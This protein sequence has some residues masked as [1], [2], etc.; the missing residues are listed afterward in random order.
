MNGFED[1]AFQDFIKGL[2]KLTRETGYEVCE[3]M[4]ESAVVDKDGNHVAYIYFHKNVG[5]YVP[6]KR[7]IERQR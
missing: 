4:D 1:V 6:R 7:R 2:S 5:R 3:G